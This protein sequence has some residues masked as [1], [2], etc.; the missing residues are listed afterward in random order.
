MVDSFKETDKE[1]IAR[2]IKEGYKS[3]IIYDIN[4]NGN[5]IKKTWNLTIDTITED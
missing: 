1:Q 5:E 4:K 2:L 3:G